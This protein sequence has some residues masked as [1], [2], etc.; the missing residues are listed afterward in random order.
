MAAPSSLRKLDAQRA[1][2]GRAAPKFETLVVHLE[3]PGRSRPLVVN[4]AHEDLTGVRI[5]QLGY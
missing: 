1:T 4:H 3:G 5:A 2:I